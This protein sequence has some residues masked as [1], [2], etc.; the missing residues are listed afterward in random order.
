LIMSVLVMLGRQLRF[1]E[2]HWMYSWRVSSDLC[3][4]LQRS[5]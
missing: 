5:H 2:K 3:L 4:Q 1:L